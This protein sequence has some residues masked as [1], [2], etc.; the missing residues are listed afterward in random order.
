MIT[1]ITDANFD[2]EVLHSDSLVFVDCY[3]DWCGPCKA[4]KPLLVELEKENEGLKLGFLDIDSNPELALRLKVVSIPKV[5]V[6]YSGEEIDSVFGISSKE[7]Y[8]EIINSSK[9]T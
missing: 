8:Q 7:R 3:A 4:L 1:A 2:Q 5:V 6:F 9:V